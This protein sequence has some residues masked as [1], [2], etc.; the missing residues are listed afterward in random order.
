MFNLTAI[1]KDIIVIKQPKQIV[2]I[3]S[4]VEDY[5]FLAKGVLPEIE[6]VILDRDR[7]GIEQIT[8]V[9]NQ[10]NNFETI[11]I[12]SHGSPG[13]LYLGNNKLSLDTL[14]RYQEKLQTWFN[15]STQQD[16]SGSDSRLLIYGCNVAVGDAGAEFINR[17]QKTIGSIIF[18]SSTPIGN[19]NKGGNW[20]L[21]FVAENVGVDLAFGQQTQNTYVHTLIVPEIDLDL[22]DSSGA[23]GN[24]YQ[25]SFMPGTPVV[26]AG[27]DATITDPSDINIESMTITLTNRPNGNAESL[28]VNGTLPNGITATGYNPNTGILALTGAASI[29]DYEAA[30]KL[31]QY[32]NTNPTDATPRAI[33]IVV[34]DGDNDSPIATTTINLATPPVINTNYQTTFTADRD[35][36]PISDPGDTVITDGDDVNLQQ[37]TITLTNR[38]DGDAVE[39]LEVD[40][41]ILPNGITVDSPYDPATGRIVLSGSASIADYQTAIAQIEYNNTNLSDLRNRLVDVVVNDGLHDSNVAQSTIRMNTPPQLDLDASNTTNTGFT[42]IFVPGAGSVRI[43]DQDT[44]ITDDSD[45]NIEAA[46]VILTNPKIGDQLLIGSNDIA[47]DGATGSFTSANDNV[48]NYATSNDGS[49]IVIRF[50]SNL[51][52]TVPLADYEELIETIAFNNEETVPDRENRRIA[53]TINDGDSSSIAARSTIRWDSDNDSIVDAIDIDDD[54]D[55]ILDTVEGFVPAGSGSQV[56]YTIAFVP[57]S[58]NNGPYQVSWNLDGTTIIRTVDNLNEFVDFLNVNDPEG[59]WTIDAGT[60]LRN[61]IETEPP[62]DLRNFYGQIDVEQ[63]STG[64]TE[65]LESNTGNIFFPDSGI[66]SDEDGYLDHLDIDADDDGIPDNIEAQTTANYIAPS[67]IA[68]DIT[69]V[70]NDGLDDNYDFGAQSGLT[71]VDTDSTLDSADGIADYL[72]S[73]SDDDGKNDIT[74]AGHNATTLSTDLDRDGLNDIFEGANLNDPFD[75]NDEID[76]PLNGVLPDTDLDAATGTPLIADLDYRDL[77]TPPVIDLNSTAS[78]VDTERDFSGTFTE[79]ENP[80]NVASI[81]ADVEDF[82]ENDLIELRIIA[83]RNTTLDNSAEVLQVNTLNIPLDVDFINDSTA[84]GTTPVNITYIAAT[85]ELLIVP[86]DGTTSISQTDLDDLIQNITYENRSQNPTNGDRTLT[87]IVTDS[88]GE[89]SPPAVS[90]ITVNDVNDPPVADDDSAQ[91][92]EDVPITLEVLI[93]DS[94]VDG[95]LDPTSVIWVNSPEGSI[96]SEDLKTLTMPGEGEYII[97]SDNG[98]VTF[99]PTINYNGTPTPVQYRVSDDDGATATAIINLTVNDVND[100]PV[101]NDDSAQ[102]DEDVPVTGNVLT[103]DFDLDGELDPTSVIFVNS[104]EG[105]IVSEDRKTLTMPGEG[106]YIIDSASGEVTFTPTINYNGTP[107]PVEYQVSDDDGATATATINLIVNDVNDPPVAD[108]DSAQTEEDNAIAINILTNDIDVDGE[109]DPTSVIWV[110]S[111]E[112]SVV[113]EDLKTL[114]VPGEGEYIIDSASGEVTFTPTIDYNGTPTPVEYQVSDD[115]GVTATATINLIVNDINDPPIADDDSAQTEEDN[116]IAINILTNDR[117]L[118][119]ELDPTSVIFV[120]SPEGSVVSEDRKTL[121]VPGEGEYIIDSA[122]G[123]VT[124]TPSLD[125]NGT[126]TPVQYQ[127][128]DD[129]G[130]TATATINLIVNDVN[131][132]PV[133]DDDSA[134]TDE[135]TAIAIN[136]LTNDRDLDGELDPAS[137]IWVNSPEGSIV[138]EDFKTLA[139]PGEGEYIIDPDNGEVTFSPSLDYNGTP[140]PV[141]YQVGDDDGATATAIIN[142]TVNDVN[143]P[144]VA[145]DDTGETDEG[146]AIAI[147]ILTN[148]L[149]VD[150]TID[151]TSVV[152]VNPPINATLSNGGKVLNV[153][154]QGEYVIDSN[155]G[156]VTFTSETGFTGTLTSV[157]YQITDDAN[158]T[159]IASISLTVNDVPVVEDEPITTAPDTPVTFNPLTTDFTDTSILELSSMTFVNPPANSSLSSDGRALTVLGNGT[160]VI[161]QTTGEVTFTPEPGFTGSLTSVE[162]QI[163]DDTGTTDINTISLIVD[164]PITTTPNTPVTFNPLTTDFT[165]TGILELSSMS[166]V[167]PPAGSGLSSDGTTLTITGQGTYV[168]NQTTGEVTF[169]PEPGFT[170]SLTSVEY[171]ITNDIGTTD[172]NTISILIEQSTPSEYSLLGQ[173]LVD[174]DNDNAFGSVDTGIEDV[175]LEL[176]AADANGNPTGALLDLAITDGNGFYEFTNLVNDNYVV[177]EIQP[178]GYDDVRETDGVTDNRIAIEIAGDNSENNSFLEQIARFDISGAVFLDTDNSKDISDGDTGI[179][180]VTLGLYTID[181]DGNIIATPLATTTTNDTGFYEFSDLFNGDYAIIR[182]LDLDGDESNRIDLTVDNSDSDG[183]DFLD[184]LPEI[185]GRVYENMPNPEDNRPLNDVEIRLFSTDIDGNVTGNAI[186]TTTTN[187]DGFYRFDGLIDGSYLIVETQPE[188]FDNPTSNSESSNRISVEIE[189][190][191]IPNNDFLEVTSVEGTASPDILIGTSISETIDGHKGQDTI[192]GGAGEDIFFYN[193]TS[194]GVDIITDFTS[195]EDRIYLSEIISNELSYDGSDPLGDGFVVLNSLGSVGTMIQIDFDSSGELLAKDVVFLEGVDAASFNP[196]TDLIF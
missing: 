96:V 165:D 29:A 128:S 148:D 41:A 3:D 36:V 15:S 2:F 120:N 138:S 19:R 157:D 101:A 140:T 121:A 183:Y 193:E 27:G 173:V 122:S 129:D 70:N 131:D 32:D 52:D 20:E 25:A 76:A 37:A 79:G 186:A 109:L 91:T 85:G 48:I 108:D 39:S 107:T 51:E 4:Q 154:E 141:E 191:D 26:I 68:T 71:P 104:P 80:F 172:I 112:G 119:G 178:A 137:V 63:I 194:D 57:D 74:E 5:Q 64:F 142:L 149:D 18:A 116:A 176:F 99:T 8:E 65:N 66:D 38:L 88:D 14:E 59:N 54:N 94:D 174:I 89:V 100:P 84:I 102:T 43:A 146:T 147:D 143:D 110:N 78:Y 67:G 162:Y 144:P 46:N 82:T 177:V 135:D 72:D 130:A 133:A 23:T 97:D 45:L 69:D 55:G 95:E 181:R 161:N 60:V 153:S 150:G 86:T 75:V 179:E 22:D 118:D 105:S 159:D 182:D 168:I 188:G 61:R 171:Q 152:F 92:D 117:D 34:N 7:D 136:I 44:L 33:E 187:E 62:A 185:S 195:N 114:A 151:P 11:H 145:N 103:N 30:I 184:E 50:T 125:Y 134:Q 42:N 47:A 73:D 127:V 81:N 83:D 16:K 58:F 190:A 1:V 31:I 192:T 170:G 113:S 56:Y 35:P 10:K 139:V 155:S 12:V 106:E 166:F 93:N 17:L 126:P 163:T 189:G 123:E 49:Q 40:E 164:E 180:D 53:V 175:T 6:K 90:T 115:D 87:F 160:Y 158:A 167:N 132:P 13:C 24:D 156:L 21:D 111:P 28:S 169:T 196:D 98:E 77:Q 124:F 9:L